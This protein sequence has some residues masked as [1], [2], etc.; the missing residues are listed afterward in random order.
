MR[1]HIRARKV[2]RLLFF[3]ILTEVLDAGPSVDSSWSELENHRARLVLSQTAEIKG[4]L[5][6]LRGAP[7]PPIG[8]ALAIEP[9]RISEIA[10]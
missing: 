3:R 4:N 9:I 7:K 1:L 2:Q 8:H 10:W 5:L 6:V